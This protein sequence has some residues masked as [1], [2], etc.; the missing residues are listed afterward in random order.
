MI[1]TI[2]SQRTSKVYLKVENKI[3]DDAKMN[4]QEKTVKT[5]QLSVPNGTF[6]AC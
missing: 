5:V 6:K 3:K 2:C 4:N 1:Q